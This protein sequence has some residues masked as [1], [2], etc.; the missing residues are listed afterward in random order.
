MIPVRRELV[1]HNWQL[2]N[3]DLDR[4]ETH[5]VAADHPDIVAALTA[6]WAA[7]VQRVHAVNPVLPP[8]ATPIDQ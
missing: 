4:G 6:D 2:Y 5:D 1:D 3:M 8:I 7:Y